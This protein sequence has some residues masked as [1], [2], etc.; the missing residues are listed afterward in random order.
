LHTVVGHERYHL[1]VMP[2]SVAIS[3]RKRTYHFP[4]LRLSRSV[5]L[6]HVLVT[7]ALRKAA[8][9]K[10]LGTVYVDDDYC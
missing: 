2:F 10:K 6:F 9:Q 4:K 5:C 7:S 8:S 3:D 1:P